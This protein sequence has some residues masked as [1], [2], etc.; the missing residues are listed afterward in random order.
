MVIKELQNIILK[1]IKYTFLMFFFLISN[2]LKISKY[3][4]ISIG[5]N[6]SANISIWI[7][8]EKIIKK[9]PMQSIFI[10]LIFSKVKVKVKTKSTQL[11]GNCWIWITR[12]IYTKM[13]NFN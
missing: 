7:W 9:K 8:Y 1:C 13:L 10:Y 6:V 12:S 2:I 5:Q 3:L 11:R 4:K